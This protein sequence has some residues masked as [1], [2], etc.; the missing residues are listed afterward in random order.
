MIDFCGILTSNIYFK[1]CLA[2]KPRFNKNLQKTSVFPRFFQC[3]LICA[4]ARFLCKM[5]IF[6]CK[7]TIFFDLSFESLLDHVFGP[8]NPPKRGLGQASALTKRLRNAP[9]ASQDA[10]NWSQ[11]AS[12]PLLDTPKTRSRRN[13]GA[14]K[15][16]QDAP[17]LPQTPP[18][19]PP[20]RQGP[21]KT[22]PNDPKMDSRSTK[23]CSF[24][25]P[26]KT[27][28]KRTLQSL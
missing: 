28:T 3:S 20:R 5:H 10:P 8:P 9:G 27:N 22:L 14:L 16:A 12:Q 17:D 24:C 2:V 1:R 21:P 23:R 18:G 7:N 6:L 13:P 15:P 11:N 26:L 25:A 19:P 4:L